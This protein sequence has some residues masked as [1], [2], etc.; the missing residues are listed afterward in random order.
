MRLIEDIVRSL[1]YYKIATVMLL[2]LDGANFIISNSIDLSYT[3][4]KSQEYSGTVVTFILKILVEVVLVIAL[5]VLIIKE[6]RKISIII[7]IM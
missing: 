3:S 7:T 5:V 6:N 1:K 4:S 2:L